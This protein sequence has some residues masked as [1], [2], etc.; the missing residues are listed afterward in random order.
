MRLAHGPHAHHQ[1]DLLGDQIDHAVV[2]LDLELQVRVA[3][4]ELRER[5]NQQCAAELDRHIDAQPPLYREPGAAHG[6]IRGLELGED[7]LTAREVF[8][9]IRGEADAAGRAMKQLAAQVLLELGNVR[10]DHRTRET[11]RLG[12]L[13][14]G[15]QI[16]HARETAH[17]C[18]LVHR[19]IVCEIRTIIS[20][21]ACFSG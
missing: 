13:G 5:R 1:V 15:V 8:G 11:E 9:A 7:S 18:E 3:R 12:R 20:R 21:L 19:Q 2:E 16:R 17:A 10:A 14:K 4:G 6:F